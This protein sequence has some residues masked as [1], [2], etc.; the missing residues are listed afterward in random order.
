MDGLGQF[1]EN[2]H[3]LTWD[4][5]QDCVVVHHQCWNHFLS[6]PG[7]SCVLQ[8]GPGCLTE[9]QGNG[10]SVWHCCCCLIRLPKRMQLHAHLMLSSYRC[11][12]IHER[13]CRHYYYC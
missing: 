10:P 2:L 13:L 9:L 12:W 6:D 5:D 4:Q 8:G 3:Q 1:W 11:Q 7:R